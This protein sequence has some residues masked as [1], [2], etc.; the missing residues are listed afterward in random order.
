[1]PF[2]HSS[3][4]V[5]AVVREPAMTPSQLK[6]LVAAGWIEIE[7]VDP[8]GRP[9]PVVCRLELPDSTQIQTSDDQHGVLARHNFA[10]GMC[11]VSLPDLD[12]ARW[13]VKA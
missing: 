1:M 8:Q 5:A 4:S 11:R 9:V 7:F 6:A 12:A 3:L 2:G 10:P 13:T